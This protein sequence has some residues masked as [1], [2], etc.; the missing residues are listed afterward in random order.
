MNVQTAAILFLMVFE[1]M[2]VT[3]LAIMLVSNFISGIHGA[4]YMPMRGKLIHGLLTFGEVKPEDIFYDLGSG[5]GRVLRTAVRDFHVARAIGYEAAPWPFW[6][7]RWLVRHSG[8]RNIEIRNQNFFDA[9]LSEAT[10]IYAY[11]LIKPIDRLAG[12][13]AKELKSGTRLII[14]SFP[15]DIQKHPQFHLKKSEKIGSITAYL[16]VKV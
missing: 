3:S 6:K 9:D 2:V 11:L 15:I 8:F 4:P 16:Y 1:L 14:P 13:F 7:S 5:D 10:C 12:K